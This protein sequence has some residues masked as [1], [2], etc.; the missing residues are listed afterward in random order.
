MLSGMT[1]TKLPE[2]LR[3]GVLGE[4]RAAAARSLLLA[5]VVIGTNLIYGALN[6]GPNRIF[7][8][9]PLDDAIPV[10]PVFAVPYVSLIPLV[11]VSLVV[12]LVL[13]VRIYRSAAFAMITAWF[14]SYAFYLVLQSYVDRP[15]IIGTD[16][17]SSMVRTIYSA[18]AP[19]NDFPSLHTSLSVIVAIHWLRID[20][21]IGIPVAL[22]TSLIVA[23]TLLI[24]QHYVADV[25]LGL[26]V[27]AGASWLAPRVLRG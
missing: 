15:M 3:Q 2:S 13:R 8:R 23:S 10:V 7:L 27:A 22:W 1:S 12:M 11:G 16:I 18:D 4:G 17:F 14:V 19:Y 6:H 25:A 21:R 5:G 20:R 26:V 24:H 9:T